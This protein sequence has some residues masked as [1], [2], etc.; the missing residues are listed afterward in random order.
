[1]NGKIFAQVRT[2]VAKYNGIAE[3]KLKA[4]TR[5]FHDLGIDGDDGDELIEAFCEA[6]EI[7]D[8]SN[9]NLAE[10]FGPEGCNPFGFLY[11]LLFAREKFRKIPIT[12]QDLAKSAQAKRWIPPQGQPKPA[13]LFRRSRTDVNPE[14]LGMD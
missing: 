1:M 8:K 3:E 10:Y 9:M 2:F 13:K 6:F 14:G 7:Q 5:L 4:D 11:D 12:L